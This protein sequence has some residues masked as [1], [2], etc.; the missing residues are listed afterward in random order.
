VLHLLYARFWHKVLFDLGYVSKPEPFQ[1]LINQGIILGE[2]N[3]KMSKSRGNIVNPDDVIDQYGADAFRCYEM[4]MGPLEQMKPWSMRGVEG[5]ARFLAR[6]WRLFMTEN[7]AGDW[8]LSARIKD[9]RPTGAQTKIT[10][11]T[12]KKVT[13]DIESLSFN[14]AISQMMIFVNAFTNE[15]AP[16]L[17]AMRSFLVL[18]NPFAPHLTSELWEKLNAKFPD[19]AG[20]ITGQKWPDYDERLLVEDEVEMVIQVNGKVRDRM[21]ISILATEEEM[22]TAALANPKTQKFTA[23]QTIRKIVVVPKKLVNIV[24][25]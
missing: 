15:K 16:P 13:T 4:F 23:G 11:A 25:D 19:N 14:T 12:T 8:E 21:K 9:L 1:R 17:S 3:Q 22:K 20:D 6:V 2:D 24:A 10:H 7:Q 18:L 5:V